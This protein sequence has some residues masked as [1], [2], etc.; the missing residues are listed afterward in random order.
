MKSRRVLAA[1]HA[2]GSAATLWT[3]QRHLRDARERDASKGAEIG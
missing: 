1:M 2:E 3:R